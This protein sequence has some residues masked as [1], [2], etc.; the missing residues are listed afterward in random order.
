MK[1]II[2]LSFA[3]LISFSGFGYENPGNKDSLSLSSNHKSTIERRPATS[4]NPLNLLLRDSRLKVTLSDN[5]NSGTVYL[6]DLLGNK[7]FEASANE[8]IDWSLAGLKSGI[9][10]VVLKD[11]K[12]SFTKK[13]L[14]KQEG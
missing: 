5:L 6:F 12:S 1:N 3:L 7:V 13:L 10:F 11:V 4:E 8:T 9:Y 14:F 2:L